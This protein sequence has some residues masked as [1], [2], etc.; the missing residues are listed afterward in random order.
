VSPLLGILVVVIL[1]V[2]AGLSVYGAI[3]A[4]RETRK[5]AMPDDGRDTGFHAAHVPASA[6][7]KKAHP[8][9]PRDWE[10]AS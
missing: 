2:V 8:Q 4:W 1:A 6:A 7:Y 10:Q 3:A 9:G 5:R